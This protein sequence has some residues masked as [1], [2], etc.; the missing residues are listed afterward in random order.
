MDRQVIRQ[1]GRLA[2]RKRETGRVVTPW[3][4]LELFSEGSKKYHRKRKKEKVCVWGG[5]EG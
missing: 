2:E 4:A 5:G 3:F 1:I